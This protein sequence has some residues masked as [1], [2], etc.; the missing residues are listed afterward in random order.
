MKKDGTQD[1]GG[2]MFNADLLVQE[3]RTGNVA[4]LPE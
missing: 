1:L 3:R 4:S 2:L